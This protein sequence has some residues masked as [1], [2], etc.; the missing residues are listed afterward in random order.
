MKRALL[1]GPLLLLLLGC[2]G[3]PSLPPEKKGAADSVVELSNE[4]VQNAE[5]HSQRITAGSFS[6]RLRLAGV[7]TGDPKHVAQVGARVAGR[8]TAIR[9]ALGDSVKEGQIL[10]EIDSAE[11]HETT[12][13]Y[14][15]ALAKARAAADAVTRQKQLVDERVGALADL[16]RLEGEAA[17]ANA[18]VAEG[19]E[20]LQFLG[21]S[22]D[23]AARIR[24]GGAD[25]ATK[26]RV[27]SP[28]GGRV[29]S[30]AASLGQAV[31]G[32]ETLA[33][34]ADVNVVTASL[35]VYERDLA[36]VRVGSRA[37]V[38]VPAY[39][40]RPFPGSVT[41]VGDV[42]D[43]ASHSADLRVDLANDDAALRPGM[44]ATAFIDRQ[45]PAEGL[46]LP[47]EAIQT[48]DGKPIIFLR[49][50]PNRF[51]ARDISVGGE[52][53]GFVL[54]QRGLGPDDDVVVHGALTLRAEL[55][56]KALEE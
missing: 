19:K 27:R 34:I 56:R 52:E 47:A 30:L 39:A 44:S 48:H 25:L 16:R 4:G 5:I 10:V 2:R 20:H 37:E 42:L 14:L 26:T 40:A 29:A 55:E 36:D 51:V 17:A 9:I 49:S 45:K 43:P 6:P 22:A 7:I 1:V 23:D 46:W 54:V 41:F 13:A 31:S 33:V 3:A 32:S 18:A 15:T 12:L 21:L 53:G 8:V 38:Q 24:T 28:I 50:A 11:L 35:R